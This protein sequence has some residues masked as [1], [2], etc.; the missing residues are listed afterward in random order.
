MKLTSALFPCLAVSRCV[1]GEYI[2]LLLIDP[3]LAFMRIIILNYLINTHKLDAASV[4]KKQLITACVTVSGKA[5][6]IWLTNQIPSGPVSMHRSIT[7][8]LKHESKFIQET[9]QS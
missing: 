2:W 4:R 5:G 6:T 9:S 7:P 3:Y 8:T 1:R